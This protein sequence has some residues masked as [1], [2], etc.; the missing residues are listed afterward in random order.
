MMFTED[1][2][3]GWNWDME[4]KQGI[5]WMDVNHVHLVGMGE[6]MGRNSFGNGNAGKHECTQTRHGYMIV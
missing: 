6:W 2:R 1:M 4:E 5:Y 3:L